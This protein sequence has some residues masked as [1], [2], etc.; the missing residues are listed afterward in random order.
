MQEILRKFLETF[1]WKFPK[2]SFE[3]FFKE[4]LKE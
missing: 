1:L 2:E 4:S 3:K